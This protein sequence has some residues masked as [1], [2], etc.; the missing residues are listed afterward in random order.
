MAPIVVV[1]NGALII[2]AIFSFILTR[3]FTFQSS[4][5]IGPA[6]LR[7]SAM[8]GAGLLINS[9]VMMGLLAVDLHYLLAQIAATGVVMIWNYIVASRWVFAAS[10]QR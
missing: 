3:S 9:V 1:S 6:A 5:A 8:F 7:F 4:E 10:A 2:S